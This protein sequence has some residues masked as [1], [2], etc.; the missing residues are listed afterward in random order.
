[1]DAFVK[2]NLKPDASKYQSL[3]E[4]TKKS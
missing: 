3:Y 2:Q 4:I 1:L